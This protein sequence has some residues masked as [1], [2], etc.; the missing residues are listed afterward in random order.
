[1]YHVAADDVAALALARSAGADGG[2]IDV[3]PLAVSPTANSKAI[4]AKAAQRSIVL[5]ANDGT[6][7]LSLPTAGRTPLRIALVELGSMTSIL[8]EL[9]ARMRDRARSSLPGRP[10]SSSF[11]IGD[12][13]SSGATRFHRSAH[14]AR[15]TRR[16]RA[17]LDA[18]LDRSGGREAG[19][20]RRRRVGPGRCGTEGDRGGPL[21]RR[22]SRR[23]ASRHDRARRR[24]AAALL[25]REAVGAPRLSIRFERA[26]LRLRLGLVV[27]VVRD[28]RAAAVRPRRS[29]P[30]APSR[31]QSRCATTRSA[32]ATRRSSSTSTAR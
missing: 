5:L 2:P 22:E 10:T 12:A 23:Q 16:R 4:A 32:P 25:R 30:T 14:R 18:S 28:R 11:A 24:A 29:A 20:G 1:M 17:R 19:Q 7:P 8:D 27:L 13:D 26:A 3:T 9:R 31:S 21:R 15:Q 6:L